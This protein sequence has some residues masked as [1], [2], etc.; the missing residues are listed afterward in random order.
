MLKR[1][2]VIITATFLLAAGPANAQEQR[3]DF[4]LFDTT[5]AIGEGAIGPQPAEGETLLLQF[6][7]SWCHSC[8]ALMWDMDEIASKNENVRY[9][10]VSIDDD[11]EAARTY[12]RKHR[13]FEKYSDRYFVD[14][15]KALSASLDVNTVPTILLVN[16]Q[17][18]VLVRRS[19]HLNAADFQDLAMAM[20][21]TR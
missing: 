12:I 1:L 21:N 16:S 19:G 7:A 8:G 2:L 5:Q 18:E 11:N 14:S 10:A 4:D 6:W 17:G 13:L 9:I 15:E 3:V 20:S